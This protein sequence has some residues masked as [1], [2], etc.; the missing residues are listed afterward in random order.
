MY[1][2]DDFIDKKNSLIL[3]DAVFFLEEAFNCQT[4]GNATPDVKY[5]KLKRESSYTRGSILNSALLVES[6]ANCCIGTLEISKPLFSDIDRL[7]PLNKF[8]Y[9]LEHV[10][11]DL[12]LNRGSLVTQEVSE[13]IGIRNSLAHPRPYKGKWVQID[14][15]RKTVD[16][17]ES[18]FLKL[19][20]SFWFCRYHHAERALKAS[21]NFLSYYFRELCQYSEHEVRSII[22]SDHDIQD[23]QR[24][25]KLHEKYKIDVGFLVNVKAVKKGEAR[26]AA[27]LR[28]QDTKHKNG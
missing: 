17:G 12:K 16:L 28:E 18:P 20:N 8:E 11:K 1:L 23:P 3:E 10:N 9:H 13:L 5:D 4:D 15:D 26:F 7:K 25:I 24:W 2:T 19:P 21:M 6:I 14:D 22:F 27:H